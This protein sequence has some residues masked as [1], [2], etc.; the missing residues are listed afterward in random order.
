MNILIPIFIIIM[1]NYIFNYIC[2]ETD[3]LNF[4]ETRFT[5]NKLY[6]DIINIIF[7]VIM[8]CIY[9]FIIRYRI[10]KFFIQSIQLF[11]TV[12]FL[13]TTST[14]KERINK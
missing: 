14:L 7:V 4:I 1:T 11:I 3:L 12:M 10:N 8:I 13:K 9:Y 2:K 6:I 5:I